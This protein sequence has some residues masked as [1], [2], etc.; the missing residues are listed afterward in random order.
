MQNQ[1]KK[2]FPQIKSNQV[3]ISCY[4]E[5]WKCLMCKIIRSVF[6]REKKPVNQSLEMQNKWNSASVKEGTL[7][8]IS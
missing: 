1:I 6:F 7:T 2:I 8:Q 3:M 5:E 4:Q